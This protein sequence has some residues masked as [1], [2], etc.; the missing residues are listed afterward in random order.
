MSIAHFNT[1]TSGGKTRFTRDFPCPVCRGS[2][3]NARH[4]GTRCAG[5]L[6]GNWIHCTRDEFGAGCRHHA[7]SSPPTWSHKHKGPC[8][9]GVEHNP[10]DFVL[11][12][13][14]ATLLRPKTVH[15][16]DLKAIDAARFGARQEITGGQKA[17][18][19]E[20]RRVLV[21]SDRSGQRLCG[22]RT[23]R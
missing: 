10:S 3:D 14:P 8:P 11:A 6:S 20:A 23:A 1:P 13:K 16:T 9:C 15:A 5:F 21:L 17:E 7:K 19:L 18:R 22:S 12:I 4:Q 2:E